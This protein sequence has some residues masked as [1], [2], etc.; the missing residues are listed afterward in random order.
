MGFALMEAK[1]Q[2]PEKW[3]AETPYLYTLILTLKD[4][5]GNVSDIRSSR[6]GFRSVEI[7]GAGEVLINGFF[8]TGG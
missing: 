2:T 7:S 1:V 8:V 5:D 6:I 4:P 3:S